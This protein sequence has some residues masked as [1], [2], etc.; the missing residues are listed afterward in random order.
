M[1]LFTASVVVP[2]SDIGNHYVIARGRS[3]DK[4]AAALFNTIPSLTLSPARGIVGTSVR[5][6]LRGFSAGES[7]AISYQP[8]S[9]RSTVVATLTA[10]SI[11]SATVTFAVPNSAYGP[12]TVKAVGQ[13]SEAS[14]SAT[15]SV[16]PSMILV[17]SSAGAGEAIGLSL[18]G[19]GAREKVNVTL[20]VD[21]RL[22][23]TVTTNNVGSVAVI[24][25]QLTIPASLA[26]GSYQVVVTGATTG[27]RD[28]A[29]LR[30]T[31]GVTAAEEALA[32]ANRLA[33]RHHGGNPDP[34]I[35]GDA[36]SDPDGHP[37]P[38]TGGNRDAGEYR[39]TR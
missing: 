36:K 33:I 38:H 1:A 37:E 10:T 24:E 20:A 21:G 13:S 5:V 3:S 23:G 9:G 30:V 32:L 15:F 2:T 11:G 28:R 31:A 25:A 34:R 14:A 18:R 4:Q 39:H 6:S 22:L 16:T 12:R 29:T 19:F 8:G 26:P 27:A 17:P 7:V 35:H